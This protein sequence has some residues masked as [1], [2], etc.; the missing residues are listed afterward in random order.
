M[1]GGTRRERGGESHNQNILLKKFNFSIKENSDL[2]ILG[3][4][5]SHSS[6]LLA[7]VMILPLIHYSVLSTIEPTQQ[8]QHEL[9]QTFPSLVDSLRFS[10][11]NGHLL[12]TNNVIYLYIND[13]AGLINCKV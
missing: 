9:K 5:I 4:F 6:G 10:A 1:W 7:T 13:D 3:P 11:S 8:C 12:S 2:R